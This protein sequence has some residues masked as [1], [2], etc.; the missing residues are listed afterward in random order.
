MIEKKCCPD[1]NFDDHYFCTNCKTVIS[2]KELKR[3]KSIEKKYR[4]IQKDNKVCKCGHLKKEHY[5]DIGLCDKCDCN[6]FRK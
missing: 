1:Y 6:E 2:K 3:L 4:I 5:P